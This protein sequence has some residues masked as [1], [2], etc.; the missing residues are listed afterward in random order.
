MLYLGYF[1]YV[2]Q[3]IPFVVLKNSRLGDTGTCSAL[4]PC[5]GIY[6]FALMLKYSFFFKKMVLVD[7]GGY[8]IPQMQ[9]AGT[10]VYATNDTPAVNLTHNPVLWYLFKGVT[11]QRCFLFSVQT[12]QKLFQ[13]IELLFRNAR[14][15]ER[16]A[17][18]FFGFFF[19]SKV[20]RR[21]LFTIPL[22]YNSPFRRKYPAIGFYEIFFC[23]ILKKLKFKHLS[24]QA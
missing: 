8:D 6:Y 3:H 2:L 18:E 14:W 19:S 4:I 16:E 22:F 13:S 10:G 21:V 24:L 7:L 9:S 23:P 12:P 5:S 1:K 17:S 20:D 11:G 15:L